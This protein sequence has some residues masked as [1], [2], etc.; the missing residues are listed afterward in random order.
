MLPSII[1]SCA[2]TSQVLYFK[3]P[4]TDVVEHMLCT[5]L[6]WK[7]AFYLLLPFIA[8]Q[9]MQQLPQADGMFALLMQQLRLLLGTEAPFLKLNGLGLLHQFNFCQF[10]S[11]PSFP[12]AGKAA[13]KVISELL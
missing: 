7:R 10:C 11:S 8:T 13:D 2:L 4:C 9:I 6:L 12:L 5:C 3:L 1:L